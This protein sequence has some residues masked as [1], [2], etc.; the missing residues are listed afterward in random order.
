MC[1]PNKKTPSAFTLIELLLVVSVIAILT[2]AVIPSMGTYLRNQ[3]LKNAVEQIKNDLRSAQNRSLTGSLGEQTV[4][5]GGAA[6]PNNKVRYWIFK[7]WAG[8]NYYRFYADRDFTAGTTQRTLLQECANLASTA[9]SPTDNRF[10]SVQYLP[11]GVTFGISGTAYECLFF[12]MSDGAI[13]H[14][15]GSTSGVITLNQGGSN[16]NILWNYSGLI[17]N[18]N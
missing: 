9:S 16:K 4:L 11:S 10:Q 12:R 1:L 3:S 14:S 17:G 5:G 2:G 6:S 18:S 13:L 7:L 15:T 8:T